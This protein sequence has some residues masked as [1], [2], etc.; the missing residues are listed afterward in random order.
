VGDFFVFLLL[1]PSFIPLLLIGS[2][3]MDESPHL[4]IVIKVYQ[5]GSIFVASQVEDTDMVKDIFTV[6]LQ[7]LRDK[8]LGQDQ[9]VFH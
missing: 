5:D 9:P 3:R 8:K 2:V 1:S 6:A 4:G 7:A